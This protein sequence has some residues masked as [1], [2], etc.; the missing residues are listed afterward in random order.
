MTKHTHPQILILWLRC[1]HCCGDGKQSERPGQNRPWG[2]KVSRF[3]LSTITGTSRSSNLKGERLI[4]Y[5]SLSFIIIMYCIFQHYPTLLVLVSFCWIMLVMRGPVAIPSSRWKKTPGVGHCQGQPSQLKQ[6][7]WAIE[8]SFAR[9]LD[10]DRM[11][12]LKG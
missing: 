12:I 1:S 8:F 9:L 7:V 10:Y 3:K 2:G 4:V 11:A 6:V 5:V